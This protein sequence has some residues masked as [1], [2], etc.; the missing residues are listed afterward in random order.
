MSEP[1]VVSTGYKPRPIQAELHRKLRR[2]NVLVCHRRFGKTVF[3]VNHMIHKGLVNQLKNP[4]YAYLAPLYGQA[5][6]VAWDY[7]KQYAGTIP[8]A[9]SNEA[10]LRVDIPRPHL[11]DSVRYTLLGADN[12]VSLKGIYLDGVILDEYAEMN[13]STWREV[14][15][16]TLS[17]RGGWAIFIGTPKGR[18]SFYD[19]FDR[20]TN[21]IKKE[22]EERIVSP[23][24]FGAMYKA[25]QTGILSDAELESARLE[26]TEDEYEQEFECSFQAGLSGAYYSK[27]IARAEKENR[28]TGVPHDSG[29]SVDTYWDLGVNDTTC[30][31]FGQTVGR[32]IRFFDYWED[33]GVGLDVWS[34]RLKDCDFGIDKLY[35]P[36]DIKVREMTTGKSRYETMEKLGWRGRI[37]VV[38]K[39]P[40][41]DGVH[42]VRTIFSR[43]WFDKEK[44]KDGLEALRNYQRKWDS[45]NQIF[46]SQPLH[47]W[48][49]NG[50][51]A[52]RTFGVGYKEDR[53]ADGRDLPRH[54]EN[55]YDV[56]A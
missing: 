46:S 22:G 10:D 20:A 4:R 14:I 12:P 40:V 56:Y 39:L 45:K 49:S 5:K 28:I 17:D 1:K 33:S 52:F 27:E 23:E 19:L 54:C 11:G 34:K 18:N 29:A 35:M 24:W 50:A 8:G 43:C 9:T 3:S 53:G 31:W 38:E 51:D 26:M 15:R 21:G 7:L 42:A 47:N 25:S 6:R 32:E 48:A 36:H 41:D 30:I 44:C 2:F 55:E 16:P 37:K 13:P